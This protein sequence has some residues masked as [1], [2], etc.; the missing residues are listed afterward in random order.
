[1]RHRAVDET[2]AR[3][4]ERERGAAAAHPKRDSSR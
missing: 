3:D 4:G 2:R 1:L